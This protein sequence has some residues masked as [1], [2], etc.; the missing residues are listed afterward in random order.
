MKVRENVLPQSTHLMK[1]KITF[2]H[3]HEKYPRTIIAS[4]V[5]NQ[6]YRP[7]KLN[8]SPLIASTLLSC[9]PH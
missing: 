7:E 8:H 2:N 4:L 6:L 3:Y 5:M 1:I 9:I